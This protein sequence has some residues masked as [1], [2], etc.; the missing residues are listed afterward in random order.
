MPQNMNL[1]IAIT[2]I[3]LIIGAL[4]G[5]Y[6][7][8]VLDGKVDIEDQKKQKE[9]FYPIYGANKEAEKTVV[10]FYIKLSEDLTI[11]EKLENIAN[12]LSRFK[13]NHLPIEIVKIEE[14]NGD[15]A[16]IDLQEYKWNHNQDKFNKL[17]GISWRSHYFQGSTGGMITSKTLIRTFLQR[18]Y[19]GNWVDGVK[20]LYE[21]SEISKDVAQHIRLSGIKYRK[22]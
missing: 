5:A 8:K 1:T 20:F 10:N 9:H 21:G 4:V 12:R 22:Q 16:V 6:Y 19:D 14:S 13:F 17:Q 7:Y 18:D 3:T 15:I 11:K 2:I